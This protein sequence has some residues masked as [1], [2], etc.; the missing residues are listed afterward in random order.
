MS[1]FKK[2]SKF[3]STCKEF[4]ILQRPVDILFSL[5]FKKEAKNKTIK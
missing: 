1:F 4:Q 3:R 5:I 2:T